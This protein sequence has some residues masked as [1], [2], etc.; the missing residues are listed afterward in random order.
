MDPISVLFTSRKQH[1]K[2]GNFKHAHNCRIFIWQLTLKTQRVFGLSSLNYISRAQICKLFRS[3][4]GFWNVYKFGLWF[5][6][7]GEKIHVSSSSS[8]RGEGER[9][10]GVGHLLDSL[11]VGGD[12]RGAVNAVDDPSL[13]QELTTDAQHLGHWNTTLVRIHGEKNLGL[14]GTQKQSDL[15]SLWKYLICILWAHSPHAQM[16]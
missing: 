9:R 6:R 11:D 8:W 14:K 7:R 16:S 5:Q 15:F 2:E 10:R 3:L 13:L 4:L 1:R 12:A